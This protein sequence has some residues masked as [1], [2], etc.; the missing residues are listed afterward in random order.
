VKLYGFFLSSAA[1]RVRIALCL[2]GLQWET[3][4]VHLGPNRGEQQ[5]P[6]FLALN[7]QGLVPV[8]VDGAADQPSVLTQSL[9]IIEYLE[10]LYPTPAL[11]PSRPAD[12]AYVR[13]IAL[14][15]ACEIHPLNN[16]RV[17]RYLR[18]SL[19][20]SK[21]DKDAWYRHWIEQG[22]GQLETQLRR[23]PRVG[24]CA[25]GDEPGLAECCLIPQITNARR[26]G[27][28]L[29]GVPTLM[30]IHEHCMALDAF[31]RASPANQPDAQKE[32]LAWA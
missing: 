8:L 22:L 3:V 7:P 11:L 12:R 1:Y 24:R 32:L 15:I 16:K 29:S 21:D 30:R 9:A 19:H 4:P 13:A 18:G 20:A 14:A 6:E 2:K 23:Q 28:E 5:R 10:E 17:L 25:F 31:V 27:C 26:F